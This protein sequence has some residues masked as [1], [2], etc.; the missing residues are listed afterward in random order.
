MKSVINFNAPLV[1]NGKGKLYHSRNLTP[2]NGY[3]EFRFEF[4]QALCKAIANYSQT[5][6]K[7]VNEKYASDTYIWY[8]ERQLTTPIIT[9]FNN[10]SDAC[11][12]ELP[13]KR[14]FKDKRVKRKKLEGRIDYWALFK[15]TDYYIE[16]KHFIRKAKSSDLTAINK[17]YKDD[18]GKLLRT[19][20]HI[21]GDR[22]IQNKSPKCLLIHTIALHL[23]QDE[24]ENSKNLN[25]TCGKFLNSLSQNETLEYDEL[26]L[27]EF[28]KIIA[29][30]LWTGK[31]DNKYVWPYLIIGFKN[32]Y[33]KKSQQKS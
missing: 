1:L 32:V 28:H 19:I 24:Y 20:K 2:R 25:E 33:V 26:F 8:G 31:N 22:L 14:D 27:F 5:I 7:K 3:S 6:S 13:V 12:S 30:K 21:D 18:K 23:R 4:A 16:F 15:E 11:I 29:N 10:V 17:A 9:A